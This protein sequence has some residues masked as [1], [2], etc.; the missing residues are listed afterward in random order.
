M[1]PLSS[2][3]TIGPSPG[4]MSFASDPYDSDH[5]FVVQEIE[6]L[7]PNMRRYAR[8]LTRNPDDADDVVQDALVSALA[9]QHQFQPGTNLRAWLFT[10]IRNAFHD[11]IRR[12]R[13]QVAMP[14]DEG[15]HPS[16]EASQEQ[17]VRCGE[18]A[19][20]F[21]RLPT[22][23]REV[24]GLVVF[25]GMSYEQTAVILGVRLGTVRSRLSR[26]R[27]MLSASLT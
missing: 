8:A 21:R 25:E 22:N 16:T 24:I 23:S 6:T 11:R 7:L 10:I 3:I 2:S 5:E 18:V 26:A 27:S 14:L 12:N 19:R 17:H 1:T 20:A 15:L 13:K 4:A 9:K